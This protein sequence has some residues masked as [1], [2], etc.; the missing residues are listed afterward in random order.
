MNDF[1]GDIS[2]SE[3]ENRHGKRATHP[4]H[5]YGDNVR[6][7]FVAGALI[8]LVTLPFFKDFISVPVSYYIMAM[9]FLG[10]VAG[11]TNPRH[12]WVVIFN[13]AISIYAIF[14][15]ESEAISAFDFYQREI[16][17]FWT[18]QL[19]AFIF[20]MSLYYAAKTERGAWFRHRR[21]ENNE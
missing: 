16:W 13:V 15:F 1:D 7:L 14:F 18:N 20:L 21:H 6:K 10:L 8:M 11:F 9:I 2:D 4:Q 12:R 17:Y 3:Q 19:L 5:Y